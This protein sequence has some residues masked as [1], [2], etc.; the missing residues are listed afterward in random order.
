[1]SNLQVYVLFSDHTQLWWLRGLK[2]G[3]RHCFVL[4]HNNINWFVL[5]PMLNRLE[6]QQLP[7]GS[8]FDLGAW[9]KQQN[10]MVLPAVIN[11][12]PLCPVWPWQFY[13]CVSVA[14]KFLGLCAWRIITPWQLYKFLRVSSTSNL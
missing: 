4:W 10:Y 3:F 8:D 9:L 13:S 1:M 7:Q 14:K 6:W 2:R 5:D 12:S 11:T